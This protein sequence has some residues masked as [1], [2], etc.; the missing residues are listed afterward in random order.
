MIRI[1][2]VLSL[3]CAAVIASAQDHRQDQWIYRDN[4]HWDRSWNDRPFP[5]AGACFFTDRDFKGN[6]S[7]VRKGDR[8]PALPGDFGDNISS[9]QI[10]GRT[11]VVVFNDRSFRGGGHELRD[12]VGDLR[13]V[14]FR[15][16]HT[17]NN[18][19]SSMVVR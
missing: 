4:P 16:G 5:Q 15:G 11:R 6:R 3:L 13:N 17:W 10:F 7:S 12:S 1:W 18:R 9:I 8:L 19:I 2:L 14:P